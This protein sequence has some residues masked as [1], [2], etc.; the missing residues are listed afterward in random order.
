MFQQGSVD[1]LTIDAPAVFRPLDQP[2]RAQ[3]KKL[4]AT[5]SCR[6]IVI[7]GAIPPPEAARHHHLA[8]QGGTG[9]LPAV[10]P[11]RNA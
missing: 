2:S 1:T 4:L 9:P 10:D 6:R 11:D 8:S 7:E 5:P 3:L